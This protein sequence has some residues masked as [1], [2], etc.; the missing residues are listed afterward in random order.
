[1]SHV[2]SRTHI[3]KYC[4]PHNPSGLGYVW[5]DG[6]PHYFKGS[7]HGTQESLRQYKEYCDSLRKH[8]G[9][10]K[11][12]PGLVLA[13]LDYSK[14]RHDGQPE[15]IHRRSVL[16]LLAEEYPA[17][18]AN[19]FGPV[20][21]QEFRRKLVNTNLARSYVNQQI[22]R[23]RR[24]FRWGVAQELVRVETLQALNAVEG[25]RQGEGGRESKKVLPAPMHHV[26]QA[27][28]ASSP[29]IAAAI[30]VMSRTGMRASNACALRWD[31]IDRTS[32]IWLYRPEQHKSKHRGKLLI[33]PLGPVCQEYLK[34]LPGK[35]PNEYLLSPQ[36]SAY[37]HTEQRGTK[38]PTINRRITK[39][40]NKD[41][42]REAIAKACKRAN[43][44]RFRPHQLRHG[45]STAI[46][47]KHGIESA[48]LY[49]GHAS[50][51][52]TRLYSERDIA[53]A[54]ELARDFG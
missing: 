23:V 7:P 2:G 34:A 19:D 51:D 54:C 18:L 26:E 32:D 48:R 11:K 30:V 10:T 53:A 29:T 3:P 13:F 8:P 20:K 25:L 21:L 31:A 1:M 33:I 44:P 15:Y 14:E 6:K 37:W 49:L 41:S 16:M 43:V 47:A 4:G 39:Q 24:M 38:T 52:V 50:V 36:D 40:Y 35:Q 12:I 22:Q 45:I 46:T 28:K 5:R 9:D 42:L 27:I 17:C